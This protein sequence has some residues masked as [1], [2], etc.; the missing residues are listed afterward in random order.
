MTADIWQTTMALV[1]RR[2][3]GSVSGIFPLPASVQRVTGRRLQT[4]R[5]ATGRGR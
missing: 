5:L 1:V 3:V 4:H 2:A